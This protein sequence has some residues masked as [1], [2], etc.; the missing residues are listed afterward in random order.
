MPRR[1][2][3]ILIEDG[4]NLVRRALQRV[5]SSDKSARLEPSLKDLA[6]AC[7]MWAEAKALLGDDPAPGPTVKDKGAQAHKLP[8]SGK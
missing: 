8:R 7:A 1:K 2:H 5:E 4:A 6:E 3:Q